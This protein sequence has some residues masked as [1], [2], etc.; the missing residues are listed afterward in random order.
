MFT[1]FNYCKLATKIKHFYQIGKWMGTGNNVTVVDTPGFGDSDG[2]EA[3]LID[4]MVK[5]LKTEVKETNIFLLLFNGGNQRVHSGLHRMLRDLE[6]MF[7]K[8]F[9]FH[10]MIGFTF[11]QFD[12]GSIEERMRK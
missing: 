11:W 8:K 9:W 4:G 7:G 12:K 2:Q 1:T 6:L 5:V 3:E 10:V